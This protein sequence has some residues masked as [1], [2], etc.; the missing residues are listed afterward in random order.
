MS[1]AESAAGQRGWRSLLWPAAMTL[2][3]LPVLLALGVWQLERLAWKEG[4]IAS[5][6]EGLGKPPAPLEQPAEAWKK[7][8]AHEYLPVS[9]TGRFRHADERH[10]FTSQ[11]GQTGW[12]VYTP[13]ETEAGHLVFVNRGFVPD[14]LKEPATRQAGQ[15]GGRVTVSGLLRK[16]GVH[17]WFEPAPDEARNMWYWRDLGGFTATLRPGIAADRVL[18]LF[19]DA[20][21]EPANP[22]GWPKG[23]AT[24]LDI[25]NRHLEYALTWFGLAATLLAVFAAFTWTRLRS[26]A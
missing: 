9:V 22:G 8:V 10:L 21:A 12:H 4:L 6:N 25:P 18:P 13:L 14:T 26:P 23:G 3:M 1:A 7:L 17:G 15:V 24:R 19:V 2:A 16:P 11:N 20:A 5:I